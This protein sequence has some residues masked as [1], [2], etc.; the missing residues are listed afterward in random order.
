MFKLGANY[1]GSL[2][3]PVLAGSG[4]RLAAALVAEERLVLGLTARA[5]SQM[6]LARLRKV[7]S[8]AD[9]K[10]VARTL[11][12]STHENATPIRVL[13]NAC[14]H[15]PGAARP[16]GAVLIGY[17]GIR[18]FSPRPVRFPD[19]FV[20][21]QN[22]LQVERWQSCSSPWAAAWRWWGWWRWPPILRVCM[23]PSKHFCALFAGTATLRLKWTPVAAT[24]H[25]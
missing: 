21:F 17:L 5:V 3:T 11:G 1:V 7:F 12:L 20:G 22:Q 8:R 24:R 15:L 2:Q 18:T 13:H 10:A 25:D 6:T 14:A 23:P 16:L 9:G 4:E 19:F